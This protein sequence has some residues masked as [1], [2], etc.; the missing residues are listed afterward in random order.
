MWGLDFR[1]GL[2]APSAPALDAYRRL[3]RG[4]ELILV[5]PEDNLYSSVIDLPKVRY[6]WISPVIDESKTAGFFYFL[7]IIVSTGEFLHP[8]HTALYEQRLRDW[9]APGFDSLATVIMARSE[10]EVAETIR[11]SPDRDFFIPDNLALI[12]DAAH[13]KVRRGPGGFFL[14]S[15]HT[16]PRAKG[17][18]RPGTL[19]YHANS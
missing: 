18:P 7:G 10:Q 9:H 15:D 1:Q 5:S 11:G 16:L 6:E 3:D 17:P 12:A 8:A 19:G 13:R 4:N 2:T 14:L